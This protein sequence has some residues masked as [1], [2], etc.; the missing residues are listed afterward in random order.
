MALKKSAKPT[1]P[2]RIKM[3]VNIFFDL[4]NQ[5][6]THARNKICMQDELQI[7]YGT[8]LQGCNNILASKNACRVPSHFERAII[9]L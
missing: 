1:R 2:A 7:L 3:R 8:E 9:I 4:A 6:Q 5:C